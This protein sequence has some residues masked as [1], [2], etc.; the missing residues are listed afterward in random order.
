[1]DNPYAPPQSSIDQNPTAATTS[2]LA[3]R[4]MRLLAAL[5]DTVIGAGVSMV[6]IFVIMGLDLKGLGNVSMATQAQLAVM[7]VVAFLAL[8][9]YL[10]AKKGQTIGK[11]VC[12]IRIA[13][14]DGNIPEFLPLILKRYLPVWL[15]AQI[16]VIGGL[17]NLVN[18]LFIFRSDKRCVHDLIAG[19]RV[20]K[21][22]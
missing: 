16:P 15:V 5:V 17:L 9:G 6:L 20:I 12:D 11:L 3:S 4:W 1:M 7:G 2:V 19:T 21:A 10:L 13:K 22:S 8:H 14:L 18:V